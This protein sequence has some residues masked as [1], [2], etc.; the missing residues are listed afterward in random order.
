MATFHVDYLNGSNT[1]DGSAANPYAT[2]KYALE[3]NSLGSGDDVKVAGGGETTVDSAATFAANNQL[4]TS[5][6]LTTSISVI[7]VT[8]DTI[9]P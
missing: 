4:T 1:N 5:S 7:A 2:V 6:D 3:T 9:Q 8:Y